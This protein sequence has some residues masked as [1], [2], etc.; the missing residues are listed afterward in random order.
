MAITGFNGSGKSTL[1]QI[2]AGYI[3]PSSGEVEHFFNDQKIHPDIL[4]R[5]IGLA[6]PYLELIEEFTLNELVVFYNKFKQLHDTSS[7]IK[8][9]ES[10]HASFAADKQIK[11]YSSGMKQRVMLALAMMADVPFIM[12]DEP[13]TNLDQEG[14]EWCDKLIN[15]HKK[16]KI[17][18]VSSNRVKEETGFCNKSIN[19][20]EYKRG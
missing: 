7:I 16:N 18:F 6:A 14:V 13:H 12:L 10:S 17:V 19:I 11:Y 2:I 9:I 8:V 15:A 4:Y 3:S 5:Y 20:E 1:L